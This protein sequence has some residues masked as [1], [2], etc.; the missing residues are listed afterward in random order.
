MPVLRTA[1]LIES[2]P[3]NSQRGGTSGRPDDRH[4]L[5]DGDDA[6]QVVSNTEGEVSAVVRQSKVVSGALTM[7]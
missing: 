6:A 5:S 2:V 1:D 3:R 4:R 7:L